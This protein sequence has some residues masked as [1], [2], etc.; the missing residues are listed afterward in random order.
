MSL[1][2]QHAMTF[3]QIIV[4]KKILV[5]GK[6]SQISHQYLFELLPMPHFPKPVRYLSCI[7]VL[8]LR[9]VGLKT[10]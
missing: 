6:G 7:Q 8:N 2:V 1:H 3:V 9:K 10:S 5:P 4:V